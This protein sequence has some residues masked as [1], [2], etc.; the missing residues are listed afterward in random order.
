VER[1]ADARSGEAVTLRRLRGLQLGFFARRR[2]VRAADG[3]RALTH[4]QL[5]APR[6]VERADAELLMI[7][8]AFDGVGAS[9]VL[10]RGRRDMP[11]DLAVWI[12]RAAAHGLEY[13]ER[14]GGSDLRVAVGDGEVLCGRD[15]DVVLLLAPWLPGSPSGDRYSAP[16]EHAGGAGGMPAAIFS[17]GVLLW[18]LL[19]REPVLPGQQTTL[20]SVDTVRIEVPPALTAVTMRAVELR[21]EDRFSHADELAEALDE[22]LERLASGYGPETAA[23]WLREHVPDEEGEAW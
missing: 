18:E 3:L 16:E 17:L 4:E 23:R 10:R 2:F 1:A 11:I 19:A 15:G 7:Y 12:A 20:R 9:V 5:L 22:V 6:A 13:V 14:M 21:P 8:P